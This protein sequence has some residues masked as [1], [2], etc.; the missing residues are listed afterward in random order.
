MFN[1]L[2]NSDY[3][4]IP[5]TWLEI[6]SLAFLSS[7]GLFSKAGLGFLF[8]GVGLSSP[9]A[10]PCASMLVDGDEQRPLVFWWEKSR[11]WLWQKPIY[12]HQQGFV[13]SR[14]LHVKACPAPWRQHLWALPEFQLCSAAPP[15]LWVSGGACSFSTVLRTDQFPVLYCVRFFPCSEAIS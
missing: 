15:R 11:R 9:E 10:G 7:G 5:H 3:R 6:Y 8:R 2:N 13:L 12:W 1:L 4:H 14:G